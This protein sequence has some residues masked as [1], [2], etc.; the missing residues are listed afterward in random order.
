MR[1]V[2]LFF[3]VPLAACCAQTPIEVREAAKEGFEQRW[4]AFHSDTRTFLP[5]S[6]KWK[7][8]DLKR[9]YSELCQEREKLYYD[10]GK[11][12][13]AQP[14]RMA[15]YRKSEQK[16]VGGYSMP[17]PFAYNGAYPGYNASI[18]TLGGKQLLAMEA[19]TSRNQGMFFDILSRYGVT[20]LVRLTPLLEK[21]IER[22]A[23]YWEGK[24]NISPKTGKPTVVIEGREMNYTMTDFWPDQHGIDPYRLIALVKDVMANTDPNQVIAVHCHAGIGRTGTFLTAY[25]LIQEIDEQIAGGVSPD[26]VQVS[27]DKAIWEVS[28][29]RISA[30]GCSDQ[31]ITLYKL[32]GA[33]LG[34]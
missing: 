14:Q 21:G 30:V 23:P 9:Q 2:T 26:R 22:T 31:Y 8:G 7:E 24:I 6:P 33:Y 16:V 32:V 12:P 15:E 18:V 27:V 1:F 4:E 20:D 10:L 3:F 17:A 34:L 25:R 29:Q 19:P 5:W 13:E 28:L 11:E